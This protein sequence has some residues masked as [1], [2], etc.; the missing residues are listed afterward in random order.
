MQYGLSILK[1]LYD[2]WMLKYFVTSRKIEIKEIKIHFYFFFFLNAS[3][4]MFE[5][6]KLI[7]TIK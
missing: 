1:T 3:C 2:H 5:K 4:F 7:Q 6:L